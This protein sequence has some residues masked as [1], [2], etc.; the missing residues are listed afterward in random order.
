[1]Y[2]D[3]RFK[4]RHVVLIL[5]FF[6]S[7]HTIISEWTTKKRKKKTINSILG[8]QVLLLSKYY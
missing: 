5:L 3:K 4:A 7:M 8:L 2:K 6:Q 1:M